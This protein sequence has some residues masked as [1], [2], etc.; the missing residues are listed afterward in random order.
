MANVSGRFV[1]SFPS[2]EEIPQ[3]ESKAVR[4]GAGSMTTIRTS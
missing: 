2:T 4:A 3:W 1:P